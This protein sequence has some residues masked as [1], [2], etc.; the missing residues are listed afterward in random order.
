MNKQEF[1]AALTAIGSEEDEAKRNGLIADLMEEGG[2][3]YD[4]HAAVIQQRDQFAVNN[5]ELRAE[6]KRL[7]LRVGDHQEP[8]KPEGQPEPK[9][10]RSFADLFDN[11]GGLK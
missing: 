6:N 4:D 10:K 9:Q 2:K 11:K 3:I 1:N 8:A 5:E 7:F